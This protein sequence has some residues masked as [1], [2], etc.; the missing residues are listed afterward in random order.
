MKKQHHTVSEFYLRGFAGPAPKKGQ[1]DGFWVYRRGQGEPRFQPPET[2]S[3]RSNFYSYRG[4]DGIRH[5]DVEDALGG[6]EGAAAPLVR[7]ICSG[8]AAFT[9]QERTH[10][11]FYIACAW[12]RTTQH[13]DA[14][15]TLAEQAAKGKLSEFFTDEARMRQ[16]AAEYERDT[17]V[18]VDCDGI[19]EAIAN[20]GLGL[21]PSEAGKVMFS[22]SVAPEVAAVIFGMR[23]VVLEAAP[24]TCFVTSDVPVVLASQTSDAMWP[25]IAW[26]DRELEVTFPLDATHCLLLTHD[27]GRSGFVSCAR[28]TVDAIVRRQARAAHNEVYAPRK[29]PIVARLL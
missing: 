21:T 2:S 28:V 16:K 14:A 10:M 25:E 29:S 13:R 4:D 22:L 23:W 7:R 17:G 1:A 15:V 20:G 6:L 26:G 19:R 12:T 3:I 27:D 5:L 8:H 11:S 24:G 18:H 9:P